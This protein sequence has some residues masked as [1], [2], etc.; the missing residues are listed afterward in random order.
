[1]DS[2]MIDFFKNVSIKG[3]VAYSIVSLAGVIEREYPQKER[4][5]WCDLISFLSSYTQLEMLDEWHEMACDR[6]PDS[7]LEFPAYRADIFTTLTLDDFDLLQNLFK[8]SPSYILRLIEAIFDIA[9]LEMYGAI[10]PPASESLSN[11]VRF[12]D[13]IISNRMPLIDYHGF[14]KHEPTDTFYG[15]SFK[16]P[17]PEILLNLKQ[18]QSRSILK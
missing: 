11:L 18:D 2:T 4:Y 7:V 13:I 16:M 8:G 3:R 9:T 10:N 14:L 15:D 17:D 12:V 5:H 6:M 1:M